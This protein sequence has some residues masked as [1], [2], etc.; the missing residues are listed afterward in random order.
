MEERQKD[1]YRPV[2]TEE[3]P[4]AREHDPVGAKEELMQA[5]GTS[6]PPAPVKKRR[7]GLIVGITAG[8]A[9]LL[10]LIVG[11]ALLFA[12]SD[13]TTQ[14]D[15][16]SDY[17]FFQS[18]N[19]YKITGENTIARADPN[20]AVT[21]TFTDSK[22]DTELELQE[23]YEKCIPSIVGV[24][25]GLNSGY[26]WGTGVVMTADGY[27]LTNTHVLEKASDV[28]VSLT[29]GRIFPAK[30]VGCD[31][32]SD[33]AVLKVEAT[34]LTPAEFADSGN[35]RVGDSV[36]A[37]GNPLS[38]KFGGTMTDGIISGVSRNVSY[39]GR[40]QTLLQTNAALNEGNSGGALFNRY[41][42][43]IGITNMKMMTTA[44]ATVEG[45][46]FA[47]PTATVQTVVKDLL[48]DGEMRPCLGVYVYA[49]EKSDD[50]GPAGLEVNSV[51]RNSDAAAQGV[52]TGDIITE[53]NGQPIKNFDAVT[54]LLMELHA[55]DTVT[56]KIWRNGTFL[57]K[58]VKLIPQSDF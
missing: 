14:G 28:Q 34:D 37:I 27:I 42:Q 9:L 20:P 55:G 11:T 24:A 29:D 26:S 3:T 40:T 31:P 51:S 30:L 16:Y 17:G 25:A 18:E 2:Q 41:G 8:I 53:I 48:E 43:V 23:L 5:Y 1:W 4:T 47:I 44:D 45:I 10:A 7:W 19:G 36:A 56:L 52:K 13:D 35:V 54:E 33:I 12:D 46:G 21:L 39:G 58:T 50:A 38:G 49:K 57:E 32:V 6:E 22:E 15:D